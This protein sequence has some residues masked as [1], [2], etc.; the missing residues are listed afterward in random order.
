MAQRGEGFKRGRQA[1]V[2]S[3]QSSVLGQN[4]DLGSSAELIPSGSDS[5]AED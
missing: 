1:E 3:L 4:P 2:L 5:L